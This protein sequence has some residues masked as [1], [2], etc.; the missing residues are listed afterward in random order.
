MASGKRLRD[1]WGPVRGRGAEVSAAVA[2]DPEPPKRPPGRKN[3]RDWCRGKESRAHVPVIVFRPPV[4]R[5]H[6]PRTC[7]WGHGLIREEI[8]WQCHHEEHCRSCGKILRSRL[9]VDECPGYPGSAEQKAAAQAQ[10]EA[11]LAGVAA[12]RARRRP[13][14]TGPQGYRR[15]RQEKAS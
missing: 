2:S 13:V 3:T 6:P 15:K 8:G 4:F 1:S 9:A 10:L 7:E 11:V 12:W 5:R 14:I